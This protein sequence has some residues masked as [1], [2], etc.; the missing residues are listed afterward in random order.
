MQISVPVLP[1]DDETAL[2]GRVLVAEHQAY[3]LALK[4]VASGRARVEGDR[5][6]IDGAPGPKIIQVSQAGS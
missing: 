4:L 2:A 3:P 5:V 6:M 1:G